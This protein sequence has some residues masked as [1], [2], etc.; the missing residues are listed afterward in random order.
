MPQVQSEPHSTLQLESHKVLHD[1]AGGL[2]R[3][4]LHDQCILLGR[5]GLPLQRWAQLV[6]PPASV[7]QLTILKSVAI[8]GAED[9]ALVTGGYASKLNGFEMSS[10]EAR[11]IADCASS[12]SYRHEPVHRIRGRSR[13]QQVARL[14]CQYCQ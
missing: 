14:H 2:L 6:E 11:T 8:S 1:D 10:T 4:H 5:E 7:T 13:P 3:S 12:L 9:L